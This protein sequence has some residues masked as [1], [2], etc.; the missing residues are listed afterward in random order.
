MCEAEGLSEGDYAQEPPAIA[1]AIAARE[2]R[3]ADG[4]AGCECGHAQ[5]GH[6]FSDDVCAVPDCP[7]DGYRRTAQPAPGHVL[8]RRGTIAVRD[9]EIEMLGARIAELSEALTEAAGHVEAVDQNS[10]LAIGGW[11]ELAKRETDQ[12]G[13]FAQPA[14]ELDDYEPGSVDLPS[15]E[16]DIEEIAV[17]PRTELGTAWRLL[18]EARAELATLRELHRVVGHFAGEWAGLLTTLPDDYDCEMTCAEA[19]AAAG[20][21]RALGDDAT[22]QAVITAHAE[23]DDDE[24]RTSH[25]EG[26]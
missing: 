5:T 10:E 22:A 11:L 19:N 18:E 12:I 24:E 8:V 7:C 13:Q 21:Y 20:L 3:A 14:P 2:P 4:P 26:K 16:R 15:G 6:A 17:V 23:H 9:A 1:E 25:V